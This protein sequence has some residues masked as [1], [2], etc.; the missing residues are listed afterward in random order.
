LKNKFGEGYTLI[1]QTAPTGVEE[2]FNR[3]KQESGRRRSSSMM[4]RKIK[5]AQRWEHDLDGL[6]D[7]IEEAFPDSI[8]KDIHPGFVHY[9]ILH[10][11]KVSWG[12][13]FEKME[14]AKDRFKLDAYS[15]GQTS[16][17]QV[18]LNFTKAQINLEGQEKKSK[19]CLCF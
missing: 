14:I 13:I 10:S 16:L 1:A 7:F 3:A 8:L 18:F 17:E 19:P 4:L 9:H 12:K 5:S 6:R 2:D 11:E 15:V